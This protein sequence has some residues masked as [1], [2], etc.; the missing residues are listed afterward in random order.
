MASSSVIVEGD[1]VS[2][3]SLAIVNRGWFGEIAR[4]GNVELAIRAEPTAMPIP[5]RAGE[6]LEPLRARRLDDA[7][8]TVR[9]LWPPRTTNVRRGAYVQVQPWEF[10]ALPRAWLAWREVADEIW[11]YSSFVAR[12]Y[13]DAGFAPEHVHVIPLGFDPQAYFP[14][15]TAPVIPT[16]RRCVFLFVGA[17]I[18]RKGVDVLVNAYL[19]AFKPTDDVALIVKDVDPGGVYRGQSIAAQIR[20]FSNPSLARLVYSAH[21]F[22]DEAA[23]ADLYRSA[24]C[25][26]HPYRG[27]GFGLPVLEAMA[28]GLPVIVTRGGATDDFVSRECGFLV[29]AKRVSAGFVTSEELAGEPWLLEPDI[30]QLIDAMRQVYDNP[31]DAR[32]RPTS[33]C[34]RRVGLDVGSRGSPDRGAVERAARHRHER[35]EASGRGPGAR[36]V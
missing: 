6:L 14:K 32:A 29:D 17:T 30:H 3:G 2:A 1:F 20:S 35:A 25:L 23:M 5:G 10:G 28:C 7:D 26:V 36:A 21:V 19:N 8:V 22:P 11:C 15:K 12:A 16:G 9:H 34:P 24:T 31:D 33:S 13:L 4:R 27:E 18:R